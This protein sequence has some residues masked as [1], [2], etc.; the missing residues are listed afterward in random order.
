MKE[1]AAEMELLRSNL[2]P[3]PISN[4]RPHVGEFLDD[5]VGGLARAVAGAG[6]DADQLGLRAGGDSLQRGGIFEAMAWDDAIV[7]VGSGGEDGR[8]GGAGTDVVIGRIGPQG[9]EI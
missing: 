9:P 5:L 6:F 2:H 8:I 1:W 3:R 4:E 7:G